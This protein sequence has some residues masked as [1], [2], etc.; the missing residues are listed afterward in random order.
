LETEKIIVRGSNW[1][2]DAVMTL[3]AL[4]ALRSLFP[5]AQIDILARK[6]SAPVYSYCPDISNLIEYE[7]ERGFGS[8]ASLRDMSAKIK[9]NGYQISIVFPN[10]FESALLFRLAGIPKVYGY[11]TDFRSAILTKAIEV[12]RDKRS[13]HEV[14][15]Y[16]NLI[17]KLFGNGASEWSDA[18]KIRLAIPSEDV[19]EVKRLLSSMG[20]KSNRPLIGFSPSAAFGPAKCWPVENYSNL[21]VKLLEAFPEG[22]IL[23]F[24]TDEDVEI[25]KRIIASI[26]DGGIDLCGKTSLKQ[27][28]CAISCLDL[29]VTNDSG[30]MHIAAAC[31]IPIVALFGSTNPVTTG[32]WSDKAI[33]IRHELPCSPCLSRECPRDFICMLGIGV[34]EVFEAC[35]KS[36]I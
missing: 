13:K 12:P 33:V 1:I 19:E 16:L 23:V 5:S 7:K 18:L 26:G 29:M 28:I 2:G 11:N 34:Q 17:E 14:F 36:L 35:K 25:G 24:G 27:A 31:D 15:Y 6:W 9:R 22:K 3:P 30:L 20:Y 10:S 32:P 4:A 8:L 21:A